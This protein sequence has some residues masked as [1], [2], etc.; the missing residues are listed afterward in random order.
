MQR[1]SD[2]QKPKHK[3]NSTISKSLP[4][5]R[6]PNEICRLGP[7][8]GSTATFG[9]IVGPSLSSRVATRHGATLHPHPQQRAQHTHDP[10]STPHPEERAQHASRRPHGEE[11][12]MAT[13]LERLIL[14]SVRST[15]LEG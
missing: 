8:W 15:R 14:R 11:R 7:P 10:H 4:P 3:Q 9:E 2:V 6:L 13:R 12:R 1:P 5:N